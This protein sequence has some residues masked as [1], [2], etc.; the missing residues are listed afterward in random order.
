MFKPFGPKKI[1]FLKFLFLWFRKAKTT[2]TQ[3]KRIYVEN[4]S[5]KYVAVKN[6]KVKDLESPTQFYLVAILKI[7]SPTLTLQSMSTVQHLICSQWINANLFHYLIN[8]KSNILRVLRTRTQVRLLLIFTSK[9]KNLFGM[10]FIGLKIW[11]TKTKFS[12]NKSL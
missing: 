12:Q 10:I 5:D 11:W 2:N 8:K 3:H 1:I 9:K 4:H 6:H 7:Y